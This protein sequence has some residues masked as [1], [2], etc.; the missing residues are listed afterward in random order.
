MRSL[1]FYVAVSL[2]GFIADT[3]GGWSAFDDS[4][5]VLRQLFAEY[6]ETCP[7][8]ARAPLGVTAPNRHFDAVIMGRRT[9]QPALDAGLTSAYP[10][11]HQYVIT[12][13]DDLPA[14]PTV[15]VSDDPLALVRGLK[16]SPGKDLW[17]CGGGE[18]AGQLLEE[19]DVFRFKINKVLLGA[20]VPL[21]GNR[22]VT[23][24]LEEIGRRP[25]SEQVD[26][27]EFRP[28]R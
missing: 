24:Q 6:P 3:S 25:L 8:P 2:D 19:I 11:L 28:A 17:L 15:T 26:L 10:H 16:E 14:D 27:V 7:A 22:A 20:G 1:I 5:A 9:H 12:H 21:F 13:H 23:L 18:L 4:P